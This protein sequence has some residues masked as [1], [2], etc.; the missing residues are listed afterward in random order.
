ME[1]V[2]YAALLGQAAPVQPADEEELII[3]PIP[4]LL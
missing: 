1:I 4:L 2:W 3:V